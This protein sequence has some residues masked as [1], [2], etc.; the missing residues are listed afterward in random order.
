[1]IIIHWILAMVL[2]NELRMRGSLYIK[3][4]LLLKHAHWSTPNDQEEKS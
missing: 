3:A 1:M 4:V 2:T